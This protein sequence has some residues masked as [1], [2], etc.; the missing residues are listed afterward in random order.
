MTTTGKI[1]IRERVSFPR[2]DEVLDASDLGGKRESFAITIRWYLKW[3]RDNGLVASVDTALGFFAWAEREKN[4]KPYA[5]ES[6]K[7]ALRWFFREASR[8]SGVECRLDNAGLPDW[9]KRLIT[10]LRVENKSYRTEETYVGWCKRYMEYASG[11]KEGAASIA[12]LE[13][14]LD[15][16]AYEGRVSASTQRQALNALVYFFRE[17]LEQEL[18]DMMEYRRARV[19]RRLPV[20]LSHSE[21][22]ALF[23]ALSGT[24]RLMANLQYGSGLRVSELIRLRIKDVDFDNRYVVVRAG[25]GDKDRRTLLPESL[26]DMLS[27]HISRLKV[28]FQEDQQSGLAGVYLP[29]SVASKYP[30]A[31]VRWEWQW[32][33]PSR[34]LSVDP[35]TGI[36]RRH[37]VMPNRYQNAIKEAARR[38]GIA[39]AVSTHAL[40]HSFATH[41]LEAGTD[42]RTVQDLLGHQSVETTQIYTHVMRRPGLGITSPMDRL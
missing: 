2:W 29:P 33:W 19:M 39:K 41:M 8:V 36:E 21:M 11:A 3:C 40:R 37:H 23:G 22:Q 32:V 1:A 31:G 10:R 6:W 30:K 16:L 5:L 25:K 26:V 34:K 27:A 4:P 28:L 24:Y 35:R 38:A 42:I 18:P 9:Q 14:F 7:E 12:T 13:G 20:V 17:V 15:G